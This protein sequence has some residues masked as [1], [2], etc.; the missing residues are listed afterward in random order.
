MSK[1]KRMIKEANPPCMTWQ[2]EIEQFD[3]SVKLAVAISQ[4]LR[5]ERKRSSGLEKISRT[6]KMLRTAISSLS[7]LLASAISSAVSEN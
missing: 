7:V 1:F 2:N 3:E 4:R 6:L 5:K